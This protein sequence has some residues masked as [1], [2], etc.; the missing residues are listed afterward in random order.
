[1]FS[2]RG[3]LLFGK[4]GK[5]GASRQQHLYLLPREEE[6]VFSFREN[7][8]RDQLVSDG[9][10]NETAAAVQEGLFESSTLAQRDSLLRPRQ[11]P[12]K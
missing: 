6:D 9:E 7:P 11:K 10:R 3:D 5:H 8:A 2:S 1:M 4:S 12:R